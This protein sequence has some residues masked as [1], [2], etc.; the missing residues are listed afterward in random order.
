MTKQI[1]N[2]YKRLSDGT[3][4]A[5]VDC[6]Y[7]HT[8]IER[9][10]VG[11]TITVST[12]K[13]EHHEREIAAVVTEYKSGMV[14]RLVADEQIA[15]TA[16]ARYA[17]KVA[18]RTAAKTSAPK[19]REQLAREYDDINNEGHRGGGYNPY[20]DDAGYDDS[21][22]LGQVIEHHRPAGKDAEFLIWI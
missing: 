2:T 12:S 5:Y 19:S 14:V 10:Q 15:A 8:A 16:A 20:R 11:D 6:G 9:P 4:G 3:F 13:G 21:R 22:D 17:A 1:A 18:E 7:R